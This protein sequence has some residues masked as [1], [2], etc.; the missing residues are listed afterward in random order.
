[1]LGLACA[2]PETTLLRWLQRSAPSLMKRQVL[3]R[4]QT[5]RQAGWKKVAQGI[6]TP[7]EVIRAT[8]LEENLD[9]A[10]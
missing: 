6:T 1:M 4:M 10:E 5:M 7:E 9:S 8:Q 2:T 3:S